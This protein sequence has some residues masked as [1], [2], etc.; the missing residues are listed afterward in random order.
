MAFFGKDT[1]RFDKFAKSKNNNTNHHYNTKYHGDNRLVDV[2]NDTKKY[3]E[4]HP[5]EVPNSTKINIYSLEE[6]KN[7]PNIVDQHVIEII[8]DDSFNLAIKYVSQ[9]L[10]PLVL[11]MASNFKPGGGVASGKMAQE[12]ELF[13]RSNAHQTHPYNWY[14]LEENEIIYSPEVTIIKD[15]NANNYELIDEVNISMVACA[16][17]RNPK[18]IHGIYSAGDYQLMSD[19]IE[20]LFMLG[21]EKKHDSLVLGAFGCGAFH[22]PPD[23]VAS[24]F[25]LMVKKYGKYFKKIGFAILIVKPTD[26][27]NLDYFKQIFKL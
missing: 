11:N 4:K 19:K 13:R 1:R 3:F 14:P 6:I 27:E 21:I 25:S 5:R 9:G 18:L 2:W 12:E 17:I 16:A 7:D 10:N 15:T 24:I 8:N 26:N 20:S 23:E 22:N